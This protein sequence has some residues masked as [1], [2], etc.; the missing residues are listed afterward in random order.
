M[1]LRNI[2]GAKEFVAAHPLVFNEQTALL[3]AGHWRE[4]FAP[5]QPLHLEIGMGRGRFI[6]ESAAAF[7]HISFL[8]LEIREEMVMQAIEKLDDLPAPPDNLRFLWLNAAALAEL[9]APGEL[10]MIY[11]NFPDPWPKTK[12]AR[13]R[14]TAPSFISQYAAIL[15]PG[16]CLRFK[17]DNQRLF[18]WSE[19]NFRA[20]GWN[21]LELDGDL[22]P[23][24]SGMITEYERRYR[25]LGQPIYFLAAAPPAPQ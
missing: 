11:L 16:G 9:F 13:R 2:P 18:H 1:R 4:L 8:G 12:H 3:Q 17:T 14:L 15:K 23:E 25:R 22:S 6:C 19:L 20:A 5:G 10:D 7:P 24:R 21:I